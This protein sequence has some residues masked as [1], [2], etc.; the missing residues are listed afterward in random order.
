M[1][2]IKWGMFVVDGRG[3]VGGH[4]LTK[5]K[6]GAI[7]RTKV[8]PSNPRTQAQ[9]LVRAIMATVSSAWSALT[10]E[11]I[12]AWNEQ[13]PEWAGT[14]VFGDTVEPS[15]KT[16]HQSLNLNLLNTGQP[17]ITVPPV[18]VATPDDILQTAEFDLTAEEL[19]LTGTDTTAGKVVVVEATPPVSRGTTNVKKLYRKVY[20]APA[21]SYTPGDAFDGY[22]DKFG[23]PTAGNRIFVRVK[24][25][26]PN[27][28]A[29]I[30]SAVVA[31]I[32]P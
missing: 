10:Q 15:G 17:V 22:A 12:S 16:L 20:H 21:D 18:K 6:S 5:N 19:N 1:A 7:V 9:Q 14:N 2:K 31:D 30:P 29:S 23:T 32:T 11:Q 4:V 27:G 24:Y 13:A 3:K 28:Q 25:V 8:T 26:M